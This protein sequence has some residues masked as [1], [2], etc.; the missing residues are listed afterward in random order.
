MA[1]SFSKSSS[2]RRGVKDVMTKDEAKQVI[3]N[4]E[5]WHRIRFTIPSK[6]A[7]E[8][9]IRFAKYR[10]ASNI[11]EYLTL[12]KEEPFQYDDLLDDVK[13]GITIIE[14]IEKPKD[15]PNK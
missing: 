13:R 11:A 3:A 9:K 15:W 6:W 4:A 14:P 2:G 5:D 8:A 10:V 12:N 1:I 7:G